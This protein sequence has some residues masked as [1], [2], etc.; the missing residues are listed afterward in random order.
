MPIPERRFLPAR[1]ARLRE[2]QEHVTIL[3]CRHD[4]KGW[5]YDVIRA[6]GQM[7]PD[8]SERELEEIQK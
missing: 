3:Q 2:S 5:R 6:D 4:G 1:G 7:I 8:V